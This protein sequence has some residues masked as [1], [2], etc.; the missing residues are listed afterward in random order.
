MVTMIAVLVSLLLSQVDGNTT[1]GI[2][3]P[4]LQRPLP[5]RMTV[6]WRTA[7]PTTSHVEYG[8]TPN[9]GNVM[10]NLSSIYLHQITLSNLQPNTLYYYV[11]KSSSG[12]QLVF[13][14]NGTFRTPPIDASPFT[15]IHM[16]ETHDEEVVSTFSS[17]VLSVKPHLIA[18]ASDF[19]DDGTKILEYDRMFTLGQD[20]YRHVPLAV[21]IGNHSYTPGLNLK[22]WK[23][24]M[25]NPGN[26]EWFTLRYG[27]TQFWFLNSTWYFN[28]SPLGKA[29]VQW[30]KASL[31]QAN[32]GVNDPVHRVAVFH[33]PPYSSGP[34]SRELLERWWVRKHFFGHLK[35]YGVKLILVGHDKFNEHSLKDGVH[36]AQVATGELFPKLETP[37][38]HSQWLNV[39]QRAMGVVEV[40]GPQM[41]YRFV[42]ST[43]AILHEFFIGP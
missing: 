23:A 12:G 26:E 13:D 17:Q 24:V 22:T 37:N 3:G 10:E 42:T 32:D 25:N 11:A 29:Q 5:T 39:A 1:D 19:V 28:P 7:I 31:Q 33:I 4:Y 30:L 20:F 21:A 14:Q 18:D 35:Q 15:F 6:C 9:L 40:N 8:T 2:F 38:P 34:L 41:K 36:I 16:A 43:G 27:N